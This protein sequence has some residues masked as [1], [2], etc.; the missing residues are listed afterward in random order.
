MLSYTFKQFLFRVSNVQFS[1]DIIFEA[2]PS[3][4]RVID[5]TTEKRRNFA[6]LL[7]KLHF[8]FTH[9]KLK[10]IVL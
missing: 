7:S 1:T 3:T 10:A 6:V 5:L 9:I 4:D 2:T 8:L